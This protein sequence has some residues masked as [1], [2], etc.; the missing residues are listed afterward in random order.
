M[1]L[2]QPPIQWLLGPPSRSRTAGTRSWQ[3]TKI[4]ADPKNNWI[5]RPF[6]TCLH[7]MY[8]DE[9]ILRYAI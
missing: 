5:L 7:D 4:G 3:I 1:G 8:K 9:F 2:T 6:N